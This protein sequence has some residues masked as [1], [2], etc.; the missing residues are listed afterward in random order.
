MSVDPN[1]MMGVLDLESVMNALTFTISEKRIILIEME[2][3]I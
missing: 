3:V 1:L 2:E